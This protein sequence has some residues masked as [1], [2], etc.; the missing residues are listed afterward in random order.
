MIGEGI[1]DARFWPILLKKSGLVF[2]SEKY[3]PEIEIH[4]FGRGFRARILR[5][6]VKKRR[7][8]RPIFRQ[9]GKTDFFNRIGR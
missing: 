9:F 1:P 2:T 5:G 4:T 6:S 7:F 8:H 3:A